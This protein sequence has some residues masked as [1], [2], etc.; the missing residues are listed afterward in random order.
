MLEHNSL[1]R[2]RTRQ[3][4][5]VIKQFRQSVLT[6]AFRGE[7]TERDPTDE[8]AQK[9]LERIKQE[10]QTKW[11]EGLRAKG[12]DPRKYKYDE[13][14][15]VMDFSL[16]SLPQC[17]LWVRVGQ[18]IDSMKN[19]LYKPAKAWGNGIPCLRMYNIYNGKI[20]L[21]ET[22]LMQVTKAEVEDWGLVAG[23]ILLNRINSRELVGKAAVIPDG[24]GKMVFEAMNIRIRI[25][26]NAMS[27]HYLT[28]FLQTLEARKRIEVRVKQTVGMGTVDQADIARWPMPL[29]PRKEQDRIVAK[30]RELFDNADD[31]ESSVDRVQRNL[32]SLERS[33]FNR[34]FRGELVPQDPNDEPASVLLE[35][36]RAQRDKPLV[37]RVPSAP[38]RAS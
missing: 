28:Y 35:R 29:A 23:D 15:T 3:L 7:L 31:L 19:G 25:L 36:I 1:A 13:P 11:A 38:R 32:Q 30:V 22:K 5:G 20:V 26:T 4:P 6:K 17:W 33:I 9:L 2:K 14:E 10:R 24:L 12:K 34:A 27:P 37:V 18:V 16:P 21:K 8:S